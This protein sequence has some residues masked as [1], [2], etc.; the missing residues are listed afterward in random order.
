MDACVPEPVLSVTGRPP[1]RRMMREQ[2]ESPVYYLTSQ[3]VDVLE[4]GYH[5]REDHHARA[6][7]SGQE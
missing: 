6:D 1:R 7:L 5:L 3:F 2:V 4:V